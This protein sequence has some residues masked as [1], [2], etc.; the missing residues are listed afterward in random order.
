M[1]TKAE[2]KE[3]VFGNN[4]DV[5]QI[6][7]NVITAI[8]FNNL[9]PILGSELFD[10]VEA[11]PNDYTDLL[12]LIKPFLAWEIRKAISHTVTHKLGNKGA[13]VAQGVNES[14]ED[15]INVKREADH[16]A[17]TYNKLLMNYLEKNKPSLWVQPEASDI[18]NKI[19]IM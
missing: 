10:D 12:E 16:F 1:I 19:I 7:D 6:K 11:N 3:L 15:V 17:T 14:P 13:M 9:L 4:F 2:I 18:F 8:K 5:N